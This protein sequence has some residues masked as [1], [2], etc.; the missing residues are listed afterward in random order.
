MTRYSVAQLDEIAPLPCPCG[1]ARRAFADLAGAPA[2]VHV[3]EI[4]ADAR[5]HYH[6]RLTET[7]VVLDGR[8][9]LELDGQTVPVRPMTAVMIRPGCRHRAV[10]R[11]RIL[12]I[13]VPPFDPAD[14]WFDQTA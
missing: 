2:S 7:Y 8:G 6:R 1:Q 12:N 10:G 13:V 4:S 5:P 14:E 11:L 3:V 9:H